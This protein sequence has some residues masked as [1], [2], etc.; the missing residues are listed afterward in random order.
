MRRAM[1]LFEFESASARSPLVERVWQTQSVPEESFIAVA[2][3]QWEMVVTRQHGRA[4]LT[5]LGPS[6][7]ATTAPIPEDA[8]FFGIQFSIGTFM[9]TLPPGAL[10]DRG[11]TLSPSARSSAWLDGYRIELPDRDDVDS[12]I[13]ALVRR[14]L[15]VRDPL[16]A[17][18]VDGH[19]HDLSARSVERRVSRATGLTRGGIRQIRRAER[20]VT[21]LSQGATPIDVAVAAGYS[22]Q[23]HLTRSL[24]RFAG[25][26]PAQIAS[27]A[28][29]A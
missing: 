20:A 12:F 28:A 11:I 1:D 2:V 8:E 23:P 27:A 14:D 26:T 13:A 21:M 10:I 17:A 9:P 22:D 18:A 15:L 19:A 3:S 25:E 4:A 24:R 16:V 7:R 5:V 29:R 6:T